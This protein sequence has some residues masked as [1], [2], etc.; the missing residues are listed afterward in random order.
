MTMHAPQARLQQVIERFDQVEARLGSTA[1]PDEIVKLSKEHAELKPVAEKAS[2]LKAARYELADL[3]EMMQSDD[4]EMVEIARE[5]FFAI[6]E[7]CRR[8]IWK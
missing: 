4:P 2:A 6:K 5:E 1:D 8:S 3:A 7:A